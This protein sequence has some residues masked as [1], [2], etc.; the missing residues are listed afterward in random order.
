MLP[1][2]VHCSPRVLPS[3]PLP[4]LAGQHRFESHKGLFALLGT[5]EE[6]WVQGGTA[7]SPS[8][9][10]WGMHD[11]LPRGRVSLTDPHGIP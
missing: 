10:D 7:R 2:Q 8:A 1:A 11:Q 5:L 6:P 3:G 9:Q 4:T